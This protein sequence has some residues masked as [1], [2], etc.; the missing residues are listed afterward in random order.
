[1]IF[2]SKQQVSLYLCV[3]IVNLLQY[4]DKNIN[5]RLKILKKNI[6]KQDY[7]IKR[8]H[9]TKKSLPKQLVIIHKD[10]TEI[11]KIHRVSFNAYTGVC[12]T[13]SWN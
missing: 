9:I 5:K 11:R 3:K 10:I 1:M 7:L 13:R 4:K 8:I 2:I 6:K 12:T